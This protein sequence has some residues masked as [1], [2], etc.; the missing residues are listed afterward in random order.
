[1]V[2]DNQWSVISGQWSV[3]PLNLDSAGTLGVNP[4]ADDLRGA[5]AILSGCRGG[6]VRKRGPWQFW[7]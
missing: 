3:N 7:F 4:G 6:L 5:A 2:S 1:V